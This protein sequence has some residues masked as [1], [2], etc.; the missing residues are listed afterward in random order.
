[1]LLLWNTV[2]EM[3]DEN[4]RTTNDEQRLSESCTVKME[5]GWGQEEGFLVS[6]LT[7]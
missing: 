3:S 6:G 4:F 2:S 5:G 7:F 1:M